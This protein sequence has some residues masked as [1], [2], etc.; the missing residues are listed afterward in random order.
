[1]MSAVH[2]QNAMS[3]PSWVCGLKQEV[4]YL[5]VGQVLSHPSWVCGLKLRELMGH[6]SI[7]SH[8]LRGCV[9]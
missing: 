1:M 3:H 9:D 7:S 5:D 6:T 8:T 2:L 4:S